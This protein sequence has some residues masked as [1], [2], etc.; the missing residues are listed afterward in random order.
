MVNSPLLFLRATPSFSFHFARC[1]VRPRFV[2]APLCGEANCAR[3][4]NKDLASISC[5]ARAPTPQNFF[6]KKVCCAPCFPRS[7]RGSRKL[8]TYCRLACILTNTSHIGH[9]NPVQAC[10]PA[11][12]T[13]YFVSTCFQR[14][15]QKQCLHA[16]VFFYPN[17]SK[18]T[19]NRLHTTVLVVGAGL[20]L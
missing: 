11:L 4:L 9:L 8:Y 10:V 3:C 2:L 13:S 6:L 19:S 18:P 17:C 12:G 5:R 1:S 14:K 7:I 15:N 20:R 16:I